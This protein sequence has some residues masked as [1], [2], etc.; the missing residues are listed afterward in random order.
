M[1]FGLAQTYWSRWQCWCWFAAAAVDVHWVAATAAPVSPTSPVLPFPCRCQPNLALNQAMGASCALTGLSHH[2]RTTSTVLF[3]IDWQ[4]IAPIALPA[5][6]TSTSF[7]L[8]PNKSA[9]Y[10]IIRWKRERNGRFYKFICQLTRTNWIIV[11]PFQLTTLFV[12]LPTRQLRTCP[13]I[14]P[15]VNGTGQIRAWN[16]PESLSHHSVPTTLTVPANWKTTFRHGASQG[17]KAQ[18]PSPFLI[19]A[20]VWSLALKGDT[21]CPAYTSL[22]EW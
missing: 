2:Y 20:T 4:L 19:S 21:A 6:A 15:P 22:C 17:K 13:V 10:V 7:Q 16:E 18:P 9:K 8:T 1:A 12:P 5:T 3:L 11:G 14:S